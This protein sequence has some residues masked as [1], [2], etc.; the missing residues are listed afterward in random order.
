MGKAARNRRHRQQQSRAAE[1]LKRHGNT[2][3]LRADSAEAREIFEQVNAETEM[4][5]RATFLDDPLFGG[6][7]ARVT[8]MTPA[9]DLITDTGRDADRV[10]ALLFEPVHTIALKDPVTGLMH[11]ARIDVLVG[12]GWQRV[13]PRFVMA[14]LPAD[15]WGLYRTASGVELCDPYGCI[16]AEGRLTLDPEWVSAAVSVGSVMVF[17]GPSLGVRIPPGRSPESYTDRDRAREFRGGAA[18]MACWPPPL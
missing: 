4:P 2:G 13:P 3:Y 10:P 5:C 8:G 9:G 18:R 7:A 1:R 12:A 16:V 15:G 11:E 14:G 6:R 17:I